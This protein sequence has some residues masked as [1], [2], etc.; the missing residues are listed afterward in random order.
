VNLQR[1][2]ARM[3]RVARSTGHDADALLA[4]A[5]LIHQEDAAM[6]RRIGEVGLPLVPDGAVVM[7]IC[8][9]GILATGGIGTALAPV[10]LA[11][12]AGRRVEV[13][14]LETRPLLQ[15]ARLTA[16]EL[17]RGGIFCTLITD[18]MSA[19]R[20]RQGDVTCVITGADRIAANG[21]F[22]NKVG[23]YGLALAARE[24]GVPLYVAAPRTTVDLMTP[25]GDAIPIEERAPSE[26][27][28][29]AGRRT[30]PEVTAWNPAFDI[31][32]ASLVRAFLTDQGRIEPAHLSRRFAA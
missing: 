22:A 32:P 4:E 10:Y 31:T 27:T 11:H 24:H 30:A 1:A 29:L 2:L 8:N 26:I 6:C 15:G 20:L 16:W 5:I 14:V 18:G 7:T 23:T 28:E 3:E 17:S 9:T 25:C 21:D 19:W 12:E 13:I